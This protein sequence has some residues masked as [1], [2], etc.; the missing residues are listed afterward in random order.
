M[1][2][3][4]QVAC[5]DMLYF[6]TSSQ[7]LYEWEQNWCPMWTLV[8]KHM[9]FTSRLEGLAREYLAGAMGVVDQ[10]HLPPVRQF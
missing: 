2:P 1:L 3:D 5:L 10:W 9:R 7:T 8:G 6:S 4:Q